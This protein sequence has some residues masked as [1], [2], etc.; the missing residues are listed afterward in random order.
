MSQSALMETI[1]FQIQGSAD[2]PYVIRV[3]RVSNDNMRATCTCPAGIIGKHCKHR[4]SLL[5]GNTI[6][7]VSNNEHDV[8]TVRQWMVGTDVEAALNNL[9]KVE[10]DFL[11]LKK[12]V[13]AA[14]HKLA[15]ALTN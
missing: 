1:E 10:G 3:S 7:I 6:D 13:E 4:I 11:R 14:K 12:E 9:A 8:K 5:S 15:R 2:E